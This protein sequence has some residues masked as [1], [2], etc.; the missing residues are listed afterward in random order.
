MAKSNEENG[1]EKPAKKKGG[2]KKGNGVKKGERFVKDDGR[3]LNVM[4]TEAKGQFNVRGTLVTATGEGEEATSTKQIIS[5]KQTADRA[6][7]EEHY[8][9]LVEEARAKGWRSR[10]AGVLTS[11]LDEIPE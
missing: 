3:T 5:A 10:K 7:A 6:E 11:D 2:G 9:S 4:L 1:T 8:Q